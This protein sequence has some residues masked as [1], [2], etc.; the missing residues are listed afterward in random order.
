MDEAWTRYISECITFACSQKILPF[1]AS[2][3]AICIVNATRGLWSQ[4][5]KQKL[6][7]EASTQSKYAGIACVKQLH[8][9]HFYLLQHRSRDLRRTPR[10]K[11]STSGYTAT[12]IYFVHK[13]SSGF[14]PFLGGPSTQNLLEHRPLKAPKW[15]PISTTFQVVLDPELGEQV[16]EIDSTPIDAKKE[17][18][19]KDSTSLIAWAD[20]ATSQKSRSRRPASLPRGWDHLASQTSEMRKSER[21]QGKSG[22]GV[23]EDQEQVFM[24]NMFFP[25]VAHLMTFDI[26][27]ERC[28]LLV[29]PYKLDFGSCFGS[30]DRARYTEN[31]KDF[32][33][34]RI[35]L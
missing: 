22:R 11:S 23:W 29:I 35:R 4:H 30:S 7:L 15:V 33:L 19:S 5:I 6:Y 12:N 27:R 10:C 3:A 24:K 2:E 28:H 9:E 32:R 13:C 31:P 14:D 20:R 8:Y 21:S 16:S 18:A 25:D 26:V 34:I 1:A 17:G